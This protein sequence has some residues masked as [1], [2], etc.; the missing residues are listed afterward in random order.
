MAFGP[1]VFV[2]GD[3]FSTFCRSWFYY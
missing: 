3:T 2:L 1:G